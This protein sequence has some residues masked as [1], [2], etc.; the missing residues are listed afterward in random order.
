MAI[1]EIGF[2]IFSVEDEEVILGKSNDSTTEPE[3]LVKTECCILQRDFN[4]SKLRVFGQSQ[5]YKERLK[6]ANHEKNFDSVTC[7]SLV[8]ICQ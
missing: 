7:Q 8:T 3:V 1:F 2:M 4:K 5:R 6:L